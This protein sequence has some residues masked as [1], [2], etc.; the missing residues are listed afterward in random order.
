MRAAELIGAPLDEWV[1]KAEGHQ[2]VQVGSRFIV[3]TRA[4]G[5]RF[6][7]PGA[8]MHFAPSKQWQQGGPIIAREKLMI[9]P[10]LERGGDFYGTWRAVAL[11]FVGRTH[12]DVNGP[13]PLIAAMRCYV[14]SV[15]GADELPDDPT[16]P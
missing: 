7:D 6:A 15:F 11:S 4:D 13:S 9:E 3:H 14:Q 16:L 2:G 10:K 12:S 5:F 8:G 1:A